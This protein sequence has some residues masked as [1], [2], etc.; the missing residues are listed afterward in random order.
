M[1]SPA[2]PDLRQDV[3][4]R[5]GVAVE[6]AARNGGAITVAVEAQRILDDGGTGDLSLAQIAAD[7]VILASNRGFRVQFGESS[8]AGNGWSAKRRIAIQSER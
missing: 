2:T 8:L 3:L 6:K 7:I 1:R 4:S 5:A